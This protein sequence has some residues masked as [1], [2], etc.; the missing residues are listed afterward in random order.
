MPHSSPA[1]PA[2]EGRVLLDELNHR[3]RNELSSIIN[4]V[5]RK[6]IWTDNRE[7]DSHI[8]YARVRP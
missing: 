6:A 7:G 1:L 8:F 4:A 3:I 2:L 5:S